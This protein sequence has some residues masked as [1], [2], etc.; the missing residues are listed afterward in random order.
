VRKSLH[1]L[2]ARL[3]LIKISPK[4]N[5]KAWWICFI[6]II[7]RMLLNFSGVFKDFS[8]TQSLSAIYSKCSVAKS[9][10][11][12]FGQRQVNQMA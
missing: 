11:P 1:A 9:G 4:R 5:R 10:C 7:L 8:S 3:T 6:R 2:K 12:V